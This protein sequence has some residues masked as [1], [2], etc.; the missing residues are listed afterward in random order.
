MQNLRGAPLPAPLPPRNAAPGEVSDPA[1]WRKAY[2]SGDTGWDKGA[3]APPIAR[4]L[5]S[6]R[7]PRGRIAVLGCGFGHEAL[8]AAR[9][10]H[11]TVGF[12]FAPEAVAEAGR[13]AAKEGLPAR[14]EVA[15][16]FAI[17]PSHSGSFDAAIE[18]TCFCAIDPARRELYVEAVRTLLKPNGA[19][20][21]LFYLHGQPGGPPYDVTEED[22]RRL[23]AGFA[24]ETFETP[25]DSFPNRQGKE[26]LFLFRKA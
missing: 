6:G 5:R 14:F 24:W 12:D 21:G 7:V 15:D 23:F 11:E 20:L 26:R 19:L 16:L 17:P 18:H 4:L 22:L 3:A 9:G 1:Y 25:P 10:G 8:A 13:R 2:V